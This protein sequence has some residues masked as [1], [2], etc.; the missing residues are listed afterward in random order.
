MKVGEIAPDFSLPNSNNETVTLSDYRGHNVVLAFY[1]KD[2]TGVCTA[3][4]CDYRDAWADFNGMDA[5]LLAINTDSVQSHKG[6]QDK[7]QFPFQL[8]SDPDRKVAKQYK[9]AMPFINIVKRAIFV[10]DKTGRI[11]YKHT[12]LTPM[13]R[14]TSDEI[15]KVLQSMN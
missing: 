11:A 14:R 12:E 10:V 2:N 8:L 4:L 15:L 13:T 1:P 6:F 3:Q 9:S 5:V 7:Y